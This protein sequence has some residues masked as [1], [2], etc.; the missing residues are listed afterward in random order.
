MTSESL[1]NPMEGMNL[2]SGVPQYEN[3]ARIQHMNSVSELKPDGQPFEFP[4]GSRIEL[5]T[6]YDFD[7]DTKNLH[8]LWQE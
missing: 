3:F 5:P 6:S 4:S 2:F 1:Q 8:A 7:G